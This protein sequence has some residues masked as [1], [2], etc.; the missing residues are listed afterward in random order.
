MAA[1]SERTGRDSNT[2]PFTCWMTVLN[3]K[4]LILVVNFSTLETVKRL[5]RWVVTAYGESKYPATIKTICACKTK[6][7]KNRWKC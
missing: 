7:V 6:C 4:L 3:P 1:Q 2:Q 5:Q